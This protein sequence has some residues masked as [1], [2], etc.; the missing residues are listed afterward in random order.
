MIQLT[1]NEPVWRA[2]EQN[3]AAMQATF[4]QQLWLRLPQLLDPDLLKF[5]QDDLASSDFRP[6]NIPGSGGKRLPLK[7]SPSRF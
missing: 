2:S 5:V 4:S 3:L 7:A 1:R 6:Y